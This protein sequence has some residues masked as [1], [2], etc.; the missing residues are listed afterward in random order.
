MS[1]L[2]L[3]ANRSRDRDGRSSVARG[4]IRTGR[5]G[6]ERVRRRLRLWA[7]MLGLVAAGVI[8]AWKAG[9]D[10]RFV[11]KRFG[12]V[13]PGAVYR[14]GQISRPLI[15]RVLV[16]RRIAAIVDLN[17]RDRR[18]VDQQAELAAAKRLGIPVYRFPCRGDARG[19]I[20]Q[21]A[22]VI[23]TIQR[24]RRGKR[25]VLVHCRAGVKRTGTAIAFFRLLVQRWPAER[26]LDEMEQYDC[27]IRDCPPLL[28]YM[29]AG[30]PR[31][32][33]LLVERGVLAEMPEPI[34]QLRP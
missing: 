32:A 10:K 24:C 34:P 8:G 7:L 11:P 22:A 1:M 33:R 23:E 28:C 14:S 25:P 15:E 30:M 4:A 17:G 19:D 27:D 6:P 18:D 31:L 16:K 13:V 26:V 20:R 12:T 5:L 29:N 3:V 21:Y 9:L 2:R